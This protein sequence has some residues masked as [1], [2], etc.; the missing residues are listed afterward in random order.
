LAFETYLSDTHARPP[1]ATAVGYMASLAMHGPPLALFVSTWLTHSLLIG[2]S[3]PMPT[4]VRMV[5]AYQIPVSVTQAAAALGDGPGS[6]G[7]GKAQRRRGLR[8][9]SGRS[10]RRGL[11]V[12]RTIKPLPDA[13]V[14]ESNSFL[15]WLDG[16][17]GLPSNGGAG[18]DG[19]AATGDGAGEAGEG[20]NSGGGGKS[21]A[22]GG[23]AGAPTV[24]VGT[25]PAALIA[26]AAKKSSKPPAPAKG[27]PRSGAGTDHG[28]AED[29]A[30]EDDV[31]AP[32][33]PGRP[34]KASYLS[35]S[36]AAY[37]RTYEVF[38]GMPES[39]WYGGVTNYLMSIEVCVTIDGSVSTVTFQQGANNE[40][41]DRLVSS[42]IRSWRYRPRVVAG[43]PRP[44]CHPIRIEYIRGSRSFAR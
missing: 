2:Y 18:G 26:A 8:G 36:M 25:P 39:F 42:A 23:G 34:F 35:E 21:A 22:P 6:G 3:G 28:P 19:A 43:S 17:E 13:A 38:P 44:F 24:V 12:P 29:V 37:Y 20:K 11:V 10:G 4:R 15:A 32:P 31:V 5:A 1:L 14:A 7:G 40:D 16:L 30:E 41:V 27:P 9:R 33:S